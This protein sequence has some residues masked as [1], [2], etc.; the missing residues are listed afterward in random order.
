MDFRLHILRLLKAKLKEWKISAF[1][2]VEGVKASFH[3]G[4]KLW[5]LLKNMSFV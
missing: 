2:Q 5:R 3:R 1:A 4:I